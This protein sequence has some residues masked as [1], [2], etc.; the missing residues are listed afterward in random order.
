VD[1]WRFR[2][3]A[4]FT[5]T[6][7]PSNHQSTALEFCNVFH[8]SA[9]EL[10]KIVGTTGKVCQSYRSKEVTGWI[11]F[12]MQQVCVSRMFAMTGRQSPL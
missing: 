9:P 10:L 8:S 1:S 5:S 6:A 3:F 7:N 11:A 2:I 4:I 12:S